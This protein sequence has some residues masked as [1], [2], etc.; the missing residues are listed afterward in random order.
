MKFTGSQP[1]FV[2]VVA[3]SYT[4]KPDTLT[5]WQQQAAAKAASDSTYTEIR[6]ERVSYHGYNAADWEFTNSYQGVLT[7]VLDRNVIVKPGQLG[8][9]L[10]LYGPDAQWPAVYAS[11]WDQLMTSFQPPS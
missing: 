3:W 10:E 2:V 11:M 6:V 1:G 9:A 7:H 4:P 5:D 8:Y